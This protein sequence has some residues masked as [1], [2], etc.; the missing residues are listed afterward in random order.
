MRILLIG[1]TGTLGQAVAAELGLRHEVINT[2]K[3]SGDLQVDMTCQGSVHRL[4][5]SLGSFDAI[6][7]TAG[8]VA[9]S[10]LAEMSI[11]QFRSGLDDKLMGQ[12]NLAMIGKKYLN[13]GGSITLTSG[14][15]ADDPVRGGAS[16]TTVSAAVEG[17]VRAAAI[18]MP[19]GIR[20]NAVN[21]SV[22]Q[23]S[24]RGYAAFFPGFEP[25]PAARAALAYRRSV[26]GAQTGQ[27]YKVR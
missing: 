25:V 19:R 2:G 20:I 16:A 21:P 4:F 26:E 1:A 6:V 17:F 3:T 24:M 5:E 15:L 12:V 8:K 10:P 13:D 27:V 7:C 14:I 18:E 9:F 23:E 11:E 22:L